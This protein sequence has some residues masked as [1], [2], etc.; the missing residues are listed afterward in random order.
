V[1]KPFIFISCGQFTEP[2]KTLGREI[3][4]MVEGVTSLTAFFA[5][6]VHDLNGLNDNILNGLRNCA[7]FIAVIH[8]RGKIVRPDG[9][10]HVRAS[11][12]IEQE[13]AIAAYIQSAEKRPL[14]VIAFIH[15]SV[16]REGIRDLLHLNPI[17]FADE[18][19]VLAALP[20]LL[21]P[22][23]MLPATGMHVELKSQKVRIQDG[24]QICQ[25]SVHLINDSNER[26]SKYDGLVR[27]PV[28]ILKHWSAHYPGE[29]PSGDSAY[30]QFR[31]NEQ[32]TGHLQPRG[33][34]LL[35]GLDY[36]MQC[37]SESTG[38]IGV[39]DAIVQAK[40]WI[41]NREFSAEKALIDLRPVG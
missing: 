34:E 18:A 29:E 22:W 10:S 31:L 11:V 8:P 16:G 36:C 9:S 39:P 27:I 30:R 26:I 35:F 1:G 12:W 28:G 41:E 2:E 32:G 33:T 3:V 24:H 20:N 6:Q 21:A 38:G 23:K 5:E 37:A 13:I 19:E 4:R 17:R 15:E 7:G 14:P 40:I 25:L